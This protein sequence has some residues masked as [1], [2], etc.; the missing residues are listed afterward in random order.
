MMDMQAQDQVVSVD[1]N[2]QIEKPRV[3]KTDLLQTY[4]EMWNEAVDKAP[5][6]SEPDVTLQ[7]VAEVLDLDVSNVY[8]RIRELRKAF[9]AQGVTLPTMKRSREGRKSSA[10]TNFAELLNI[11]SQI[12]PAK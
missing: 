10:R 3:A 5:E 7:D 9:E 1:T 2:V 12:R 4:V 8:Q 6:G 11:A